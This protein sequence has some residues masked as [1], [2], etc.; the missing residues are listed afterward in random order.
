MKSSVFNDFDEY[1]AAIED[2][3]VRLTLPQLQREFWSLLQLNVGP[4]HVQLGVE[5]SGVIAEG[6]IASGGSL[7]YFEPDGPHSRANGVQMNSDSV[8]LMD[9]GAEFCISSQDA[10]SWCSVFLPNQLMPAVPF[11]GARILGRA[12]DVVRDLRSLVEGLV[13]SA[14]VDASVLT[15]PASRN[16]FQFSLESILR[17]LLVSPCDPSPRHR[18]RPTIGR[19]LLIKRA[20]EMA[21]DSPGLSLPVEELAARAGVSDRTLRTAFLEYFGVPPKSYLQLRRL[22]RARAALRGAA[23]DSMTVGA[24]AA[25]FGFWDFSRFADRYRRVFG[26]LPSETLRSA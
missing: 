7:L 20:M 25:R 9:A 24:V 26:E 5:G 23:S 11:R 6:A 13:L 4:I 1:A 18:G 15:E 17:R 14:A 19:R 2:A 3:D 8:L 22:H 16:A 12:T 21:E 10:Q